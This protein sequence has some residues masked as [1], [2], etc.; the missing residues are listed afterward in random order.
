MLS[1]LSL[2]LNG[3]S[4]N[5]Y[6]WDLSQRATIKGEKSHHKNKGSKWYQLWKNTETNIQLHI[7][8]RHTL[9]RTIFTTYMYYKS[10]DRTSS[11]QEL[12]DRVWGL[13]CHCR[14]TF[15]FV[16]PTAVHPWMPQLLPMYAPLHYQRNPKIKS[17]VD[18]RMVLW[19]W[20]IIIVDIRKKYWICKST[21][22][23]S[24][25]CW[26]LWPMPTNVEFR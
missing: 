5:I 20:L 2:V 22:L 21:W 1:L 3:C 11:L 4:S 13:V 23:K 8:F 24:V 6:L 7:C 17:M 19:L 15:L 16:V 25:I 12:N 14:R 10:P 9:S 26:F 18:S